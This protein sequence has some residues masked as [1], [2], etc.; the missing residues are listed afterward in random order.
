MP[1]SGIPTPLFQALKRSGIQPGQVLI[2]FYGNNLDFFAECVKR[3]QVEE[4]VEILPAVSH[5]QSVTIQRQTDI[6]FLMQSPRQSD[7]GNVPAKL[8][9]YLGAKRPIIAVGSE[10][11]VVNRIIDEREAGLLSNDPARLARKLE[12]WVKIKEETGTIPHLPD[13][14]TEGVA[15]ADQLAEYETFL[16]SLLGRN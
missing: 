16:L 14:C 2:R 8:F 7:A 5:A 4:F 15:R 1:T 12:E 13:K 3:E 6:L 9:E 10:G 11:G